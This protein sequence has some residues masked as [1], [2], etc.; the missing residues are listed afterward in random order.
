MKII[1][2]DVVLIK[3]KHKHQVSVKEVGECFFN[4]AGGLLL[5]T[6]EEHQTQPVTLWF[7]AATNK[8]RMLKVIYISDGES[9]YIKSAYQASPDIIR[10]YEK[11]GF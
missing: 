10:I 4:R 3:L 11:Y 2:S 6:R 9:I 8:N 5:D 1:V 7:V